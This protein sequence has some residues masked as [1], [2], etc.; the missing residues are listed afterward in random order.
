MM[1]WRSIVQN[2]LMLW[3]IAVV[4]QGAPATNGN[5]SRHINIQNESGGRVEIYWIHPNTREAS[6]MSNPNVMNGANFP[7]DSFIG[8]EFEVRELPS[9]QTGGYK[10]EDQECRSTF[11]AVSGNNDQGKFF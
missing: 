11:F 1:K 2:V 4:V 6:L 3:C 9:K 7:L 10:S 8:H 5:T